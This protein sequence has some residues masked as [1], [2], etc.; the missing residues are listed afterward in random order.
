MADWT[1]DVHG[2]DAAV[3][4]VTALVQRCPTHASGLFMLGRILLAANDEAG[5]AYLERA[6]EIDPGAVGAASALIASHSQQ[7][8]RG[9][10]A[11]AHRTRAEESFAEDS[12]AAAERRSIA[13]HDTLTGAALDDM[14]RAR[15]REE[16]AAHPLVA[17][18]WL[19]R[20]VTQFA[21]E[22]PYFVLGVVR[23]DSWWR[24][25]SEGSCQRLARTL[26][27]DLTLPARTLVV[28][29]DYKRSWLRR[30]LQKVANA[31]VYRRGR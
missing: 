16:L 18:A 3:P 24:Y 28:V 8:G 23:A 22:R 20:K 1:E 2:V 12:G 31:E 27:D 10:E 7:V 29:L 19:A 30:A 5:I 26:A 17:R 6:V 9:R 25:E 13:P 14:A 11:V 4:L 15:L 21:P